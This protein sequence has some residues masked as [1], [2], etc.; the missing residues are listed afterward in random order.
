[1][2]Y[3]QILVFALGSI[4]TLAMAETAL[5]TQ[6]AAPVNYHVFDLGPVGIGAA[7]FVANSGVVAGAVFATIPVQDPLVPPAPGT[8]GCVV[9]LGV[10]MGVAFDALTV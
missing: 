9:A 3:T 2:N 4:G 5:V 10:P 7:N 6:Q 1:M 8:V